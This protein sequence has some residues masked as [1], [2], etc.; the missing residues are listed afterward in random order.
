[1]TQKQSCVNPNQKAQKTVSNI[2][3]IDKIQ[4]EISKNLCRFTIKIRN[5]Y[6]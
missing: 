3:V 4:R 5:Y 6:V 1:M 2:Q